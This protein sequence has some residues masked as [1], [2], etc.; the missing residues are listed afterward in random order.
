MAGER[1]ESWCVLAGE[2]CFSSAPGLSCRGTL[3]A[4]ACSVEFPR[5]KEDQGMSGQRS[6]ATSSEQMEREAV[7]AA[8][9]PRPS[10]PLI[11]LGWG[12]I[13]AGLYFARDI[14]IPIVLAALLALLLR[15]I[16]KRMR[17][18]GLHDG[19]TAFLLIGGIAAI[20]AL[21]A[22]T[23]AGQAER[24]LAAA[25]RTVNRVRQL[26][27][28]RSGPLEKLQETTAA[29][30]DL[31]RG[32]ES[33]P[34]VQVEVQSSDVAYA[35][36]GVSGHIVGTAIIVFVLGFFLLLFS[37]SLLRQALALRPSFAQK[38]GMVET[39]ID[40]ERGVSRYLLTITMINI[41]LG[42]ATAFSLWLLGI[43]NPILWG[44]LATTANYVP[45]VGAFVCMVV[46]FFVGAVSHESLGYGVLTAG[47]FVILTS[48]ES[49]F[50][51]PLV[52]SRSLQLSPLAVILAIL[53]GGWL[54]G[55]AGA[56]MA[57]PLLAMLKIVC[58]RSPALQVY[59]ALLAGESPQPVNN[60][61]PPE[62][63]PSAPQA[64]A[65]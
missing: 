34:P 25:P 54:W 8:S 40:V 45:H 24:W 16:L 6:D 14:L 3:F 65:Q 21:G 64:A 1:P 10:W 5:K 60:V 15:P 42:V 52:L 19:L 11:V 44:V 59:S 13:L 35:L 50:I 38:R 62:V 33:A 53:L 56:L 30:Q 32:Q 51:T 55:L 22:W 2:R 12:T 23:L 47:A 28:Q 17:R 39:L 18:L 43:P 57:A 9:P 27:P 26:L 49:Y 7:T 37:E 36:L 29:V 41:C 63:L 58:D 61:A 48:A 20:F 46:L 4:F 31:A